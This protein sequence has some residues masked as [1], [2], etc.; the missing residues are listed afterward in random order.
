MEPLHG[1]GH[2]DED[3]GGQG[4]VVQSVE[5]RQ[6]VEDLIINIMLYN[7]I[8]V[9]IQHIKDLGGK[10]SVVKTNFIIRVLFLKNINHIKKCNVLC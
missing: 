5:Y 1:Y 8:F 7:F 3:G 4:C 10:V 9:Y 2:G 6:R